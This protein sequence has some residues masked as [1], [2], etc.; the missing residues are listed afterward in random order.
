MRKGSQSLQGGARCRLASW[1]WGAG[2]GL[3]IR[4][5]TRFS[6]RPH[7]VRSRIFWNNG[8]NVA[9]QQSLSPEWLR[10][11]SSCVP[12]SCFFSSFF[13][14]VLSKVYHIVVVFA[15]AEAH[16]RLSKNE[17]VYGTFG[18][19]RFLPAMNGSWLGRGERGGT[20]SGMFTRPDGPGDSRQAVPELIKKFLPLASFPLKCSYLQLLTSSKTS[21]MRSIFHRIAKGW[22]GKIGKGG[23]LR[24]QAQYLGLIFCLCQAAHFWSATLCLL[25]SYYLRHLLIGNCHTQ[26]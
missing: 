22:I 10:F 2:R 21:M 19:P 8:L 4:G 16:F 26:S 6:H 9:P 12:F 24:M 1:G 23:C 5:A 25:I 13:P 3:Y 7:S 15:E 20:G 17:N 18:K 14:Q 11:F